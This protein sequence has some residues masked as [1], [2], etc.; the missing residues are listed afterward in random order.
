VPLPDESRTLYSNRLFVATRHPR[1]VVV[2]ASQYP[3]MESSVELRELRSFVAEADEL[4]FG[5]AAQRLHMSQSPSSRGR[6]V[7]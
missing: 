7:S 1:I 3:G 5:R 6:F 2:A 4:Y